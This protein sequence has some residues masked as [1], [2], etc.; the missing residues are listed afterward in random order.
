ML[1]G[2]TW[3]KRIRHVSQADIVNTNASPLV[4]T[5]LQD[6]HKTI[7]FLAACCDRIWLTRLLWLSV[8]SQWRSLHVNLWRSLPN[9]VN[10]KAPRSLLSPSQYMMKLVCQTMDLWTDDKIN[11]R[12]IIKNLSFTYHKL[13]STQIT[14]HIII[15]TKNN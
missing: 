9:M 14:K 11:I 13:K 7:R 8:Y 10:M 6:T 3:L 2:F 1:G 5:A 12:E 4:E 15:S